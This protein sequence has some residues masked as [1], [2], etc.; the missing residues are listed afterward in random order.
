MRGSDKLGDEI[1]LQLKAKNLHGPG[2][3]VAKF[4]NSPHPRGAQITLETRMTMDGEIIILP[5]PDALEKA[6]KKPQQT[7]DYR[8]NKH[9]LNEIKQ[10]VIENRN[11]ESTTI[12]TLE[13]YFLFSKD[14][15]SAK[16]EEKTQAIQL[17]VDDNQEEKP[18][19]SKA[20]INSQGLERGVDKPIK[21]LVFALVFAF[22]F[23][24]AL[25]FSFV[26]DIRIRQSSLALNPA[27]EFHPIK[28]KRLVGS[29]DFRTPFVR[30][31][32]WPK[33]ASEKRNDPAYK[34]IR[35][36]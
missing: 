36:L 18:H 1:P 12:S 27:F 4:M 5:S 33:P 16:K 23:A 9:S 35:P 7:H 31:K 10:Y 6:I 28:R 3:T 21:L 25:I 20:F 24:F 15:I 30:E 34:K 8:I 29:G 17:N 11:G 2:S 13:E 19:N 26:Y 22:F 14:I 32:C